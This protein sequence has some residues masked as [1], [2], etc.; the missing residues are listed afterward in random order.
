MLRPKVSPPSGDQADDLTNQQEVSRDAGLA[1]ET[2]KGE[3]FAEKNVSWGVNSHM[4][5]CTAPGTEQNSN[6]A[7]YFSLVNTS[8]TLLL[9][10]P[11][12]LQFKYRKPAFLL[13]FPEQ[14]IATVRE[15]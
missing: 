10:T 11:K 6:M 5:C 12:T 15:F 7:T 4:H 1:Y 2:G 9:I 14:T 8:Y 13:L 3:P